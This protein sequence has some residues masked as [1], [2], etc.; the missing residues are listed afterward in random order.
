MVWVKLITFFQQRSITLFSPIPWNVTRT[1][2]NTVLGDSKLQKPHRYD[3]IVLADYAISIQVDF[4]MCLPSHAISR[5]QRNRTQEEAKHNT[6][7]YCPD[8]LSKSYHDFLYPT[9][10]YLIYS[11]E[12][13]FFLRAATTFC[14]CIVSDSVSLASLTSWVL[15]SLRMIHHSTRV[16]NAIHQLR[17]ILYSPV[18]VSL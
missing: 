7:H 12:Q 5:K 2:S 4:W 6:T 8:H 17:L 11:H 1:K 16:Q 13:S 10:S 15:F 14:V 9:T 3:T 18:F